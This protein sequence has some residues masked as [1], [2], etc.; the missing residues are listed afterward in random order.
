MGTVATV[1]WQVFRTA[2]GSR[3]LVY[4][5]GVALKVPA[6]DGWID[7]DAPSLPAYEWRHGAQHV[8]VVFCRHCNAW[9][10]H[11]PAE[12][13]RDNPCD[14]PDCPYR[15]TGYNLV[16]V[17]QVLDMR[18]FCHEMQ[19]SGQSITS[20]LPHGPLNGI[21]LEGRVFM[22][23]PDPEFR[24]PAPSPSSAG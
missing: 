9:N 12:G 11:L 2:A 20:M 18:E 24:P 16:R 19:A 4:N 13:H 1:G 17:G 7:F 5:D 23:V 6:P 3:S 14:R 15:D 8:F 22:P 10:S 21:D